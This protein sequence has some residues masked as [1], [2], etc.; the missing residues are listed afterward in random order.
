MHAAASA[1][2]R[3]V[4]SALA[5]G[6]WPA[7]TAFARRTF[8][9]AGA[10]ARPPGEEIS[11]IMPGLA[12]GRA[13]QPPD[14]LLAQGIR[15]VLD[16]RAEASGAGLRALRRSGLEVLRLRVPEHRPPTPGQL[17]LGAGWARKR[18]LQQR[19]ILIQ[20]REGAGRSATLAM[21]TL[22]ALGQPPF[23]AYQAVRERRPPARPSSAQLESVV[24]FDRARRPR[25]ADGGRSGPRRPRPAAAR[26]RSGSRRGSP[27]KPGR[28]GA[29]WEQ[30][31]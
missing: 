1:F 19:P 18:L 6:P 31:I 3:A 14:A 7:L 10:T 2:R 22:V 27:Q 11:W 15:A 5:A 29:P 23:A 9:H 12:V 25:A 21:A 28:A 4:Q 26:K 17:R 8:G 24:A 13:G 20:C 30:R 16:V